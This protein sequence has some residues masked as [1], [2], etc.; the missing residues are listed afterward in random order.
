MVL[1]RSQLSGA[2]L[3]ETVMELRDLDIWRASG[4]RFLLPSKM[5]AHACA[6]LRMRSRLRQ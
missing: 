5:L 3:Q 6:T 2:Q 4:W 1:A